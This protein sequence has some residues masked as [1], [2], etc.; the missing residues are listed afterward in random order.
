MSYPPQGSGGGAGTDG[1][2]GGGSV[3]VV[4]SN[5]SSSS[6]G[7]S[8]VVYTP[9]A[10]NATEQYVVFQVQAWKTGTLALTVKYAMSAANAGDVALECDY[11]KTTDAGDP[12][13]A[14]TTQASFTVTPGAQ[15]T[16]KH[17]DN[18]TD[19]TLGIAVTAGDVLIVKLTRKNIA[20]DT[21][22]GT[23]NLID[24][25]AAIA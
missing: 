24:I 20:G 1:A 3:Q 22:T 12:N 2:D 7:T 6:Y 16:Q 23:F 15:T 21:H 14:L 19:A 9:L 10:K 11:G 5:V 25:R 17:I 8:G 4:G 13:A 18:T